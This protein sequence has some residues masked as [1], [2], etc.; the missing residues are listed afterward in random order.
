MIKVFILCDDQPACILPLNSQQLQGCNCICV[1]F[2]R[3]KETSHQLNQDLSFSS[4]LLVVIII[5]PSKSFLSDESEASSCA[6][7]LLAPDAQRGIFQEA[8]NSVSWVSTALRALQSSGSRLTAGGHR[9]RGSVRGRER[10]I[11]G[12]RVDRNLFL[13]SDGG[14][15]VHFLA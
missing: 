5:F 1:T 10:E 6:S 8:L 11:G 15:L 14:T 9:G 3:E 4:L 2:K 13:L 12:G 7:F